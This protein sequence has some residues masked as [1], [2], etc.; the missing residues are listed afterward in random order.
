M[1][2]ILSRLALVVGLSLLV[3]GS[4]WAQGGDPK[5]KGEEPPAKKK[6]GEPPAPPPLKDVM[7]R[8]LAKAEEEY[9]IFFKKPETTPEFWS[10]IKFEMQV[11]K[12]DVA[13]LHLKQMLAQKPAETVDA[14]LVA[15][16]EVEGMSAFLQLKGVRQWT[17]HPILQKEA[18][19]NVE[20]LIDR[21]TAAV[22]KHL[23][24]PVRLNK[25][26]NN[27]SA[28]TVEAR[29]YAFAQLSRARGRA[30]PYLV[31][32]LRRSVGTVKHQRILDTMV[33]LD[34]EIIPPL[35]EA[36][37]A[38][39]AKDAADTDLRLSLL[40][41]IRR[42]G[43]KRAIPYLWSLSSSLRYP[44]LVRAKA[45]ETLATLL[46]TDP[47]HL[48][49]AKVMLTDLAE[50][51]YQHKIKFVDPQRVVVWPWQKDRTIG[52]KP[53]VLSARDY[54]EVFGLRYARQALELDPSYRPAQ[55]AFLNFMLERNYEDKLDQLLTG[56]S[57][58]SLDQL[59]SS[60]DSDLVMEVLERAL[61]EHNLAVILPTIKA[62]GERGE[63]RAARESPGGRPGPLVR[64]LY[65]PDRRVQ[66]AAA[67]ALLRMPE[68]P[69][70][71]ASRRVV[72]LLRRFLGSSPT[73]KV[74]VAFAPDLKA[75]TLRKQLKAA[76]F[77]AIIAR[78]LKET[79]DALHNTA[80]LDVILLHY[81]LR[82]NELPYVLSQLNADADGGLPLLFVAPAK[83]E[84]SY[85]RLLKRS[86]NSRVISEAFL[87]TPDELKTHLHE[88]IKMAAAPESVRKA[89]ERQQI[90][91][92]EDLLK[93]KNVQLTEPERKLFAAV[94]L[95]ALRKM[96]RG[97][98]KGYEVRA[99]ES[100][101]VDALRGKDTAV[102]AIEILTTFPGAPTQQRLAALVLDAGRG[103]ERVTAAKA[104]NRHVQRNGLALR[105][106]QVAQL[107]QLS[108]AP[109][110][111]PTL[112]AELAI[113][114][115]SLR[116]TAEQTGNKLYRFNP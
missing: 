36:L 7:K 17:D 76:G 83:R 32:A 68:S 31:E 108:A 37:N 47:K 72:E 40:E 78:N 64:A 25:F 98:I 52:T 14:N 41:V 109:D 35:L 45:T 92:K 54:E 96:A 65:Y 80:D 105:A 28:P 102:P 29:A 10:A 106:E 71:V 2:P 99:A 75:A 61:A 9:R 81:N 93:R 57:V 82:E 62:L 21:V 110:A 27:L 19:N 4:A 11:G 86:R 6:G 116:S 23:G 24:D 79:M 97:E 43:D 15:I 59:L 51:F 46:E 56:K 63:V 34:P 48:P 22:E 55:V 77:D 16:E 85:V 87:G 60:I 74:L 53:V 101:L 18:E 104:L 113:L 42:R 50:K 94:S 20:S 115:G 69:T 38:R 84:G 103:K 44:P 8:L 1:S 13:A 107:R 88:A 66:F 67:S 112:R 12:F 3:I 91:L 58:P 111:D 26:I 33:K 89:S 73:P 5:K 39:D 49:P 90:W 114:M 100:T 95:D 70:P 30:A